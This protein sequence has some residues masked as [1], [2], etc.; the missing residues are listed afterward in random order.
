MSNAILAAQ[1]LKIGSGV[2]QLGFALTLGVCGPRSA[3]NVAFATSFG[4][5]G[6]AYAIFNMSPPGQRSAGSFAL[7]GRAFFNWI[8][9]AAIIIFVIAFLQTA[10]RQTV[11]WLVS[12]PI[13]LATG[14]AAVIAARAYGLTF[15]EFGGTAI[16]PAT[17]LALAIFP[18]VYR[19][20]ASPAH[21]GAAFLG[22]A[23][24]IN[25]VDHL[26]AELLRPGPSPL[27]TV[28]VQIG[29]MTFI[30]GMWVWNIR[31]PNRGGPELPLMVIFCFIAPFVAGLLVRVAAGSYA[32]VQR[33]GFIGVGRL[34]STGLLAYGL[35][36]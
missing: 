17:A 30:L 26:G 1:V 34:A 32:G 7:E 4:A 3:S 19:D 35:S 6:I 25:S 11:A 18:L 9:A 20:D 16:Y 15:L 29:A 10:R 5:N 12:I 2:A 36:A 33:S 27:A 28:I 24:A 13:A 21:A 8:A 22:A 14:G 23:L 31:A